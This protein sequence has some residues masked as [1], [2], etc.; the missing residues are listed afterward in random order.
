MN[1]KT[2]LYVRAK[3]SEGRKKMDCL[4]IM[5]SV[6]TW[7]VSIK[8]VQGEAT[9]WVITVPEAEIEKIRPFL[10][11]DFIIEKEESI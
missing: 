8:E 1:A 5:F 10:R 6:S 9:C 3:K 4:N 7:P 11:R 2:V